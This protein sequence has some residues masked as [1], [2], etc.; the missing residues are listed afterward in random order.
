MHALTYGDERKPEKE[1]ILSHGARHSMA[2]DPPPL[3]TAT[4]LTT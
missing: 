3:R 4:V 2:L 1:E